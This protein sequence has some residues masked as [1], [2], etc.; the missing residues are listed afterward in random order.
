MGL[1]VQKPKYEAWQQDGEAVRVFKDEEYPKIVKA[2]KKHGAQI[3]FSDGAGVRSDYHSGTTWAEKGKT[4]VVMTT[5]AR[6]SLNMISAISPKGELRF[7]CTK[8]TV[9]SRV[10]VG[11]LK[12]LVHD[13]DRPIYLVVD[14]HPTHRSKIVKEYVNS[15]SG[16]LTLFYLPS[17]SPKLNP[18]ESVW[19]E[20]KTH[21]VGKSSISG[22]DHLKRVVVS[23]LR[24][25][26]KSPEI[27]RGL[28]RT[29]DL[30]YIT[31]D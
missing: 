8:E 13:T 28:L 1:S 26:Q 12:R 18:D 23:K 24:S 20:V 7:M 2:A 31:L 14:G 3:Y 16:K 22:P 6:L 5:G 11:F 9:T 29:P 30:A 27:L 4:P 10:Y 25:L 21:A 19:R 17:Y 15:T